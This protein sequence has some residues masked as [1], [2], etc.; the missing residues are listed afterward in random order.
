MKILLIGN[1]GQVGK[2]VQELA[3]KEN[4]P[5]IGFDIEQIDITNLKSVLAVFKDYYNS[6]FAVSCHPYVPDCHSG[7]RAY[8]L[9]SPACHSRES[10]NPDSDKFPTFIVINAAAYTAVDKA[11]DE[12]ELAYAVNTKGIENLAIACQKYNLPLIHLST[13][14]VFSGD[15]K[16]PYREDDL[17]NPL[18]VYGK[19]KLAGDQALINTWSKHIILRISWVFGK[20]G[21]NFVKTILKLAQER[22]TLNIVGDQF[23]CPTP[24]ADIARVLLILVGKIYSGKAIWGIY[25]YCGY[26]AVTWYDFAE[27]I[28]EFAQGKYLLKLQKMNKINTEQYP[29]KAKRPAN[30]ELLVEKIIRDYGIERSEWIEYLENIVKNV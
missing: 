14:Y 25:N 21:N 11:E 17:P 7:I 13:D 15:S 27:K 26:P 24:A 3:I 6:D 1:R 20:Y 5:I 28:L 12:P 10:G 29:T 22:E 2:E 23:G 30:S 19:S 9:R 4:I 16:Q 8:R 18:G